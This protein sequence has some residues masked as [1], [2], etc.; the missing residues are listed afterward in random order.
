MRCGR[1]TAPMIEE[2]QPG[3]G[4]GWN[5]LAAQ[6]DSAKLRAVVEVSRVHLHKRKRKGQDA[7]RRRR[8]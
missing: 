2:G 5:G 4:C 7:A 8:G 3:P 6:T 1:Q